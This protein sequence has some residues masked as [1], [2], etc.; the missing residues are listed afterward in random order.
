M[1]SLKSTY[2]RRLIFAI[3]V[4]LYIL[5][6][7]G[8]CTKEKLQQPPAI[9][10]AKTAN[11]IANLVQTFDWS[12]SQINNICTGE[13]MTATV[14]KVTIRNSQ[15]STGGDLTFKAHI[16]SQFKMIGEDGTEYTGGIV[17][18][19]QRTETNNGTVTMKITVKERIIASGKNNNLFFTFT[20]VIITHP[21]GTVEFG[22]DPIEELTCR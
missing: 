6:I 7:M 15:M 3:L 8:A 19:T 2:M 1:S 5:L 4:A 20:C 16:T 12:G 14:W 22:K 13:I 18:I 21:D 11:K 17:A 10:K 9:E